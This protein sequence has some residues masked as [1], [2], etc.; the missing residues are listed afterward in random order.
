[1]MFYAYLT[2]DLLHLAGRT[3]VCTLWNAANSLKTDEDQ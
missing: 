2:D 3:K 1:M